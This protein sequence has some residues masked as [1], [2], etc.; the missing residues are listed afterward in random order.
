MADGSD[1]TNFSIFEDLQNVL[2][3]DVTD[4]FKSFCLRDQGRLGYRGLQ[5]WLKFGTLS[6]CGDLCNMPKF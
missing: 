4:D 3:F 6:Y 1:E 2:G 5:I